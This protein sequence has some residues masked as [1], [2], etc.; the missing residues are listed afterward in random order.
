MHPIPRRDR[1]EYQHTSCL[2]V[3]GSDH[4]L[5]SNFKITLNPGQGA[6]NNGT[7]SLILP[8]RKIGDKLL[9]WVY[10][11]RHPV[12]INGRKTRLFRTKNRP[13]KGLKEQL[14][15]TPYLEPDVEE[16]REE[17]LRKLD[18]GLHVDKLQFGVFYRR[19]EA[20]MTAGRIFSN[21]YEVSHRDKGAG[22]L[23]FDYDHKI[24][25]IQVRL[26]AGMRSEM[27]MT[28][29]TLL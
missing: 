11:E 25:R 19:P 24:I 5:H 18:L 8:H 10:E 23:W 15:K 6:Q 13:G 9:Q 4:I 12:F 27:R 17:K 20:P 14:E 1:C 16:K 7:G 21:E 28:V 26:L 3:R 29:L 22:L 2:H